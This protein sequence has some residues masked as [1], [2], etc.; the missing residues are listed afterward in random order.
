MGPKYNGRRP[1]KRQEGEDT[2]RDAEESRPCEDGGRD[3]CG[4]QG[5]GQGLP[6]AS[7][8]WKRHRIDSLSYSP[9]GANPADTSV[10]DFLDSRTATKQ[11]LLF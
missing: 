5:K 8:S 4:L 11:I 6:T 2:Q 7:D 10:S 3:Q 1:Y 9:E